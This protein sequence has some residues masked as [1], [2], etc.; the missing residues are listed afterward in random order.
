[1]MRCPSRGGEIERLGD[2]LERVVASLKV[3]RMSAAD[4]VCLEPEGRLAEPPWQP[5]EPRS[6]A[7]VLALDDRPMAAGM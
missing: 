3:R 4:N 7:A 6:P 5:S 1:M 2:I